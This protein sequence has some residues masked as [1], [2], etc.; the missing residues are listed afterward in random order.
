V[1]P[2]LERDELRLLRGVEVE[3]IA[4]ENAAVNHQVV[5]FVKG[6][7]TIGALQ[8]ARALAHVNQLVGLRVAIEVRVVLVGLAVQHRDVLIEQEWNPI[9]GG[10]A[11]FLDARG[12]E[13]PVVECLIGI[14]LEFRLTHAPYRFHRR[15]RM[16]VI[17]ER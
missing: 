15:R 16:N 4:V 5:A 1:T 7:R 8:H 2:A 3:A 14:G 12:E 13:V 9:Q 17:H 6:Q 11:A 10:A